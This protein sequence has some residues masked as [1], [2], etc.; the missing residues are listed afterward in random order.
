MRDYILPSIMLSRLL[1]FSRKEFAVSI[2][3]VCKDFALENPSITPIKPLTSKVKAMRAVC[4]KK[5][6][7]LSNSSNFMRKENI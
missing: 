7:T 2:Q 1:P 3:R 6:L 4:E 5:W